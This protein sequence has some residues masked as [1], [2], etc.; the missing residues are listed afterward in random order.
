MNLAETTIDNNAIPSAV[1]ATKADEITYATMDDIYH[2][3]MALKKEEIAPSNEQAHWNLQEL[4]LQWHTHDGQFEFTVRTDW[5]WIIEKLK[6]YKPVPQKS[7]D[8]FVVEM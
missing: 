3:L 5:S 8:P 6:Q 1:L 4:W 7:E 2:V